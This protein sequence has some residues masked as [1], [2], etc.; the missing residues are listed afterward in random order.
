MVFSAGSRDDDDLL[1]KRDGNSGHK[2]TCSRR[3]TCAYATQEDG[4]ATNNT[5]AL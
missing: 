5:I 2:G 3:L 4:N 1:D